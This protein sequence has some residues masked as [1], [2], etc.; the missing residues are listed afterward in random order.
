MLWYNILG[1]GLSLQSLSLTGN[2]LDAFSME[3]FQ[4]GSLPLLS[5]LGNGILQELKPV[6]IEVILQPTLLPLG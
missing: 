3:L 5:E 4:P 2:Y 6:D 1:S